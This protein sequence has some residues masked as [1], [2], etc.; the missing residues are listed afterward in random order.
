MITSAASVAPSLIEKYR[1]IL[2]A[3]PRS[4]IFVELARALLD[5]G[6]TS[7]AMEVCRAGLEHHPRSILGRVTWGRALLQAGDLKGA[8]DQFDVAIGI[9]PG[10]PHAYNLVGEVLVAAGHFREAL[11]VLSRAAEMQPADAQARARLEEARR[12]AGGGTAVALPAVV[13]PAAGSAPKP[14]TAPAPGQAGPT[15]AAM[16]AVT[17]PGQDDR[18]PLDASRSTDDTRTEELT[19]Q[20]AV[21]E[22]PAGSGQPAQPPRPPPVPPGRRGGLPGPRTLLGILPPG[23][24]A[25][26]RAAATATAPDAAE[27]ARLASTYERELREKAAHAEA[28]ATAPS[29]RGRAVA[30][31][32]LAAVLAGALGTFAW[33]R[34]RSQAE[35]LERSLREARAGLARDTRGALAEAAEVLSRSRAVSPRDPRLLSLVAQVNAVLASDHGDAAAR[36]LALE[37]TDPG[38]AGDG[39]LAARWLLAGSG[40]ERAAAATALLSTPAGATPEPILL[41]LAGEVLL[42]RGELA[43]GRARLEQAARA[44]PPLLAAV[45]SLGDSHLQAGDAER[46]LAFYEGAIRAHATHPRS[47]M[48]AAEARLA[49]ARPLD[50]SLLELAAVQAD[51]ASP[52]PVRERLRFELAYA[53]VLAASGQI[54]GA[55]R[56]LTLAAGALGDSSRLE[57]ALA[58]LL[59]DA[60]RWDQAEAAAGKAIRL[61]PKV[62]DHRV[63]L[64]RARNGAHRHAAALQALDGQDGRQAWLERGIA[65]HG[66]G[67]QEQ[68]RAAL[69]KTLR[70]GRMPAEAA[71]WYARADV[72]RGR[73]DRAVTLLTRLAAAPGAG[74]LAQATLGEALLAAGR[75]ADAETACQAAVARDA[76]APEGH[77]CLGQVLLARGHAQA[78][79]ASLERALELDP[80]DPEARTLLAAARAPPAPKAP[81]KKA[82]PRK[83]RK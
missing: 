33:F 77:R 65:L 45:A 2:A 61:E 26:A 60:R 53:R 50:G 18:P 16:P 21:G 67:R 73:A 32:A 34:A 36:A 14:A 70:D 8:Q 22:G 58:S 78:A 54:D 9:D 43:S 62:V 13:A 52:P 48:G 72:A 29:R 1:Q 28:Q 6:D 49:L 40:A 42:S 12:R 56:R 68:A 38:V 82:P 66:M 10:T 39:A 11:P 20:L 83:A 25:P 31:L 75:P 46:A 15:R 4:R 23:E 35:E 37:L 27:A 41:R 19:L 30:L 5:R 76:S 57:A 44:S 17:G 51:P 24:G 55:A 79:I 74:P 64:A 69:E 7:L 3:D 47:V 71:V 81:A 80:A 59:L 63:L